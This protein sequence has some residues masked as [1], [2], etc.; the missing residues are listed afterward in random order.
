MKRKARC[1]VSTRRCF[2]I[3]F[4]VG[5][6]TKKASLSAHQTVPPNGGEHVRDQNLETNRNEASSAVG[7]GT[8]AGR[9]HAQWTRPCPVDRQS[10]KVRPGAKARSDTDP[11][12]RDTPHQANTSNTFVHCGHACCIPSPVSHATHSL[13]PAMHVTY[14]EDMFMHTLFM[15]TLHMDVH[16]QHFVGSHGMKR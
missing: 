13:R 6:R 15:H 3:P 7:Q 8:P 1:T 11:E 10:V 5:Q 16:R 9:G 2:I 4:I 12:S 14:G